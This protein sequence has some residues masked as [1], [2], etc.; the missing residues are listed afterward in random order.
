MNILPETVTK[1]KKK[2]TLVA[3]VGLIIVTMP[4]VFMYVKANDNSPTGIINRALTDNENITQI[5]HQE[6][7]KD[8][9]KVSNGAETCFEIVTRVGNYDTGHN[10]CL[11]TQDKDIG[12]YSLF[13]SLKLGFIEYNGPNALDKMDSKE[14]L[15][16]V[17][18]DVLYAM[19]NLNYKKNVSFKR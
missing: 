12:S 4:L 19:S 14:F 9:N 10:V 17:E 5:F 18:A 6:R 7:V 3:I 15:G 2:L 8:F 1:D 11:P 16:R 13:Y